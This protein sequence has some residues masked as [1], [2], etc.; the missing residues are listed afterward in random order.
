[1]CRGPYAP[2]LLRAWRAW[3]VGPF[4]PSENDSPCILD[5]PAQAGPHKLLG[6]DSHDDDDVLAGSKDQCSG[7]KMQQQ[8][9]QQLYLVLAMDDCGKDLE[10]AGVA[11]FQQAGALLTQVSGSTYQGQLEFKQ[12]CAGLKRDLMPEQTA[13][14][15][16]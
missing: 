2:D 13:W 1:V 4:G 12:F 6:D 8:A 5:E 7:R 10:K 9:Q 15:F 14:V 16:T 3:D 11:S